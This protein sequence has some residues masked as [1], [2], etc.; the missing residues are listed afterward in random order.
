MNAKDFEI[1]YWQQYILLEKELLQTDKYVTISPDNYPTYSSA[2]GKLLLEIGSEIDIVSKTL[3]CFLGDTNASIITEYAN[4]ITTQF[5]EFTSISVEVLNRSL[6]IQPWNNWTS[7][8]SPLWWQAHNKYKHDR[9]GSWKGKD[10]YKWANLENTISS[11]AGLFQIEVYAFYELVKNQNDSSK[12]P[13][14]GSRL[15]I[16]K[17]GKW[18]NVEFSQDFSLYINNKGQL[19]LEMGMFQY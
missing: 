19:M 15:F 11:L 8:N 9:L 1:Q 14:P 4:S 12:T 7:T 10:N 2:Y 16:L 18:D 5:P 3:C 17:G 6:I 13:M